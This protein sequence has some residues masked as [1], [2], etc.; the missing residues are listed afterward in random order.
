MINNVGGYESAGL[1]LLANGGISKDSYSFS[2]YPSGYY[3]SD[4]SYSRDRYSL[5]DTFAP[6]WTST[7][8]SSSNA[9]AVLFN[10]GDPQ[11]RIQ[12]EH[13]SAGYA[14]RCLRD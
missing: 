2:I 8:T 4:A 10:Q 14:I 7:F 6:F 11:V 13:I 3:D 12:R 1:V 9:Y 5:A